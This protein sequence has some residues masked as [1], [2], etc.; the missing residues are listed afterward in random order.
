[1]I[2]DTPTHFHF[3]RKHPPPTKV[4]VTWAP[5]LCDQSVTPHS[6]GQQ[7]VPWRSNPW[8]SLQG[9]YIY[10]YIKHFLRFIPNSEKNIK[11]VKYAICKI[12]YIQKDLSVHAPKKD[13]EWGGSSIEAS[14]FAE[15]DEDEIPRQSW[16][17]HY[18]E[19]YKLMHWLSWVSFLSTGFQN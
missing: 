6:H 15:I 19:K 2:L 1:M 8:I 5:S 7:V 17:P 9:R 12:W 4:T 16:N 3:W 14:H 10:I 11:Q 18:K 13:N